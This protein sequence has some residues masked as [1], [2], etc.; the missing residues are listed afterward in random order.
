MEVL[1]KPIIPVDCTELPNTVMQNFGHEEQ[2]ELTLPIS[3]L[4]KA[5]RPR[6]GM[7]RQLH[8][9]S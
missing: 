6:N 7:S 9:A 8:G 1:Q 5:L 3:C 4:G 2:M